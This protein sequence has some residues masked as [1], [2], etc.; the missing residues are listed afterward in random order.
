M[1]RAKGNDRTVANLSGN[2]SMSL[3]VREK[4]C[5]YQSALQNDSCDSDGMFWRQRQRETY[6]SPGCPGKQ[7]S[8]GGDEREHQSAVA[9]EE[10]IE[11]A[12]KVKPCCLIDTAADGRTWGSTEEGEVKESERHF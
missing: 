2:K 12:G 11:E 1:Q 10:A 8:V 9:T 7:G 6:S 3:P 5:K 4:K